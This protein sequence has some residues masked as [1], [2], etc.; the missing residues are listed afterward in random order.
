MAHRILLMDNHPKHQQV[1]HHYI[2]RMYPRVQLDTRDPMSEG[3]PDN[4]FA[5]TDYD[6]LLMGVN[7]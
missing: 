1:M 3:L 2:E 6:L 5:W 7:V 4:G